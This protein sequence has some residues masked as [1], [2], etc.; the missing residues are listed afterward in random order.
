MVQFAGASHLQKYNVCTQMKVCAY[1]LKHTAI[2]SN[3]FSAPVINLIAY[4][5]FTFTPD[6]IYFYWEVISGV[7]SN[8]PA[9]NFLLSSPVI[10]VSFYYYKLLLLSWTCASSLRLIDNKSERWCACIKLKLREETLALN[11]RRHVT[12]ADLPLAVRNE[13]ESN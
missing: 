5:N 2:M 7:R 9:R 10:P 1:M 13:L 11:N 4:V 12:S 3:A 8:S 6:Y